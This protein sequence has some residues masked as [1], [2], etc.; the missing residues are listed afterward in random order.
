MQKAKQ[1]LCKWLST[2]DLGSRHRERSLSKAS[3]FTKYA[4]IFWREENALPD[5][6]FGPVGKKVANNL[7]LR[8]TRTA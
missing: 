5:L 3:F 1:C 7:P 2:W 8:G 4:K 6:G